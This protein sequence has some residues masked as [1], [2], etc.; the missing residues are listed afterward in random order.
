MDNERMIDEL[1]QNLS[2]EEEYF[3]LDIEDMGWEEEFSEEEFD[4]EEE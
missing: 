4:E 3:E 1:L 2:E